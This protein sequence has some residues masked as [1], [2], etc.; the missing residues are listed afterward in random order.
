[1]AAAEGWVRVE[2]RGAYA[3][4]VL[5]REPVNTMNL[6]FWQQL[7]ATLDE[8]EADPQVGGQAAR[9]YSAAGSTPQ[10]AQAGPSS[11]PSSAALF[12]PLPPC[13]RCAAPS[14]APVCAA[15]CSP[16][17]TTLPSSTPR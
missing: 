14:S 10:F 5:Q 16:P 2:R 11:R 8:L 17:A 1:M 15:T 4:V 9:R 6:A 3:L 13:C 7:T 12:L